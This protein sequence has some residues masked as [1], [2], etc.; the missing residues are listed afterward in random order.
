MNNNNVSLKTDLFIN[1]SFLTCKDGGTSKTANVPLLPVQREKDRDNE[2][3]IC[4]LLH[5]ETVIQKDRAS[6]AGH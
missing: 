3:T 2:S 1:A 4:L 5:S 6:W